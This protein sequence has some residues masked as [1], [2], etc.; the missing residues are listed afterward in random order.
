MDG[1]FDTRDRDASG[2]GTAT[3]AQTP[4]GGIEHHQYRIFPRLA[5]IEQQHVDAA[6]EFRARYPAV[7]GNLRGHRVDG[8]RRRGAA[9]TF[10]M[11]TRMK[12]GLSGQE[13]APARLSGG[14]GR[15]GEI[16]QQEQRRSIDVHLGRSGLTQK[17]HTGVNF[18]P[19]V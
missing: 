15:A 19:G 8:I 1:E 17:L 2:R 18:R 9:A 5:F 14:A 16:P 13:R 12:G 7:L 10:M 3:A 4:L 6:V 11:L